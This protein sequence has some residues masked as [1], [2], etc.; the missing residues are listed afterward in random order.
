MRLGYRPHDCAEA[1]VRVKVSQFSDLTLDLQY[2][3]DDL[4]TDADRGWIH[5]RSK[6]ERVFLKGR[7]TGCYV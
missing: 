4:K 6:S 7:R 1:Y 2:I 3:D 5:L